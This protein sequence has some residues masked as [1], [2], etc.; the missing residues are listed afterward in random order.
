MLGIDGN[1]IYNIKSSNVKDD[2]TAASFSQ[3]NIVSLQMG[4]SQS[5]LMGTSMEKKKGFISGL[6]SKMSS[7]K[8]KERP[9]ASILKIERVRDN[10]LALEILFA[11]K[12][13]NKA[14]VYE[15]VTQD[16]Q[17]EI[18]SKINFLLVRYTIVLSSYLEKS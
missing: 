6:L 16:N 4:G 8:R 17:S 11:E 1:N 12:N 5:N 9:I 18:M 7:E 15:C 3:S 2:S 13:S 14:I 10:P